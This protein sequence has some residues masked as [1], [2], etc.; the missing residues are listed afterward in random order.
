MAV[1]VGLSFVTCVVVAL[2]D[3]GDVSLQSLVALSQERHFS[4]GRTATLPD[5]QAC[6]RCKP[7]GEQADRH[8][9]KLTA[10]H[11]LRQ[12]Q[13]VFITICEEQVVVLCCSLVAHDIVALV[14]A[15]ALHSPTSMIARLFVACVFVCIAAR[16]TMDVAGS[17]LEERSQGEASSNCALHG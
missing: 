16:A 12:S 7:S 14:F 13:E 8:C 4:Y 3:L 15:H 2:R 1:R 6:C 5:H 17:T 9:D 10:R 11:R